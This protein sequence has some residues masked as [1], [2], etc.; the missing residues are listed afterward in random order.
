M[1]LNIT[2]VKSSDRS[3]PRD[4]VEVPAEVAQDLKDTYEALANLP[5]NNK[6]VVDFPDKA[7]ANLFV[8]Q[9]KAWATDNELTFAR[10]GSVKENPTRVEFRIYKPNP[11]ETRGRKA[12]AEKADK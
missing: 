4:A 12:N 8:R 6:A 7:A 9:G 5:T 10:K 2:I 11:D 1:A 3:G